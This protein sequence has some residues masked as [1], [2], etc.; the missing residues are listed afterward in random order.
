MNLSQRDREK[1]FARVCGLVREK[2]FNPALNGADWELL[3][4]QRREQIIGAADPQEFEKQMR[5][6]LSQLRTSHTGFFHKSAKQMPA[7]HA[8]NVTFKN[9]I[10]AGEQK[11]VFQDVHEGGAAHVS[12]IAPGDVLLALNEVRVLPPTAP[13]FSMGGEILLTVLRPSGVINKVRVN[14]PNPKSKS[15]PINIPRAVAHESLPSGMGYLK[16]S[17]FPGAIGIDFAKEIDAA[18]KKLS[19]CD[20]LIIDLRGNSG[21]GIGGLRLM[22]YLTPDKL[23][24]GYSLTR[25]RAKTG[26]KREELRRFGKIPRHKAALPWLILKYGLGDKSICLCTEGLGSQKFHRRV[27]VLVNEHSASAAEML[28][29]FVAENKLGKIV[30]TKTAGRLLSGS[31]CNAGY[32]YILGVPTAAYLTWRGNALEGMGVLPDIEMDITYESLVAGEDVQ[33]RKAIEIVSAM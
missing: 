15:R 27:V 14:V 25:K 19:G 17:V 21:G 32:G 22:S 10:V 24:I 4:K 31:T 20:R 23:P 12:G 13:L 7:R 26:Y 18:M 11:W 6:L 5:D 9:C 8:I 30:G 28:A 2:H 1:I 29:A 3:T 16:V 33:M